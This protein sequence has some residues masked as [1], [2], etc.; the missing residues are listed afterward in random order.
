MLPLAPAF[1]QRL[2]GV[3][4]LLGFV[5]V[6]GGCGDKAASSY[7]LG[8]LLGAQS[9]F[10]ATTEGV[11]DASLAGTAVF[12]TDEEGHLIGIDLVHVD[13]STRG[14]SI[15][16][17]PHP[18]DER[19]YEVVAPNLLGVERADAPAGFLAFFE[20]G[21]HSFQAVSGTLRVTQADAASVRGTFNVRMSGMPE[22][23]SFPSADVIVDGSFQATRPGE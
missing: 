11:L 3:F 19:T 16:L 20:S 12:R 2:L 15:E 17:E 10:E 5:L 7:D 18:L 6:G 8:W 14:L 21:T 9:T 4:L 1:L 22:G 23:G 13:D